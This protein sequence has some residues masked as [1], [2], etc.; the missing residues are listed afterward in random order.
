MKMQAATSVVIS[1]TVNL[2][3]LVWTHR[4]SYQ[5]HIQDASV[6]PGGRSGNLGVVL[7]EFAAGAA[8][9]ASAT[10]TSQ[11]DERLWESIDR[12]M[13]V[14]S[15]LYFIQT[16]TGTQIQENHL[17]RQKQEEIQKVCLGLSS[18]RVDR[19]EEENWSHETTLGNCGH[20]RLPLSTY[21]SWKATSVMRL[22]HVC[23]GGINACCCHTGI[24]SSNVTAH[25]GSDWCA[26]AELNTCSAGKPTLRCIGASDVF[27]CTLWRSAV[28]RREPIEHR[29]PPAEPPLPLNKPGKL[30]KRFGGG[31]NENLHGEAA[32]MNARPTVKSEGVSIIHANEKLLEV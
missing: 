13:Q 19:G 8:S 31:G 9:E 27:V 26:L 15:N 28:Q 6:N 12:Y 23:K 3:A 18:F 22:V 21:S 17:L 29:R 4:L 24:E 5:S 32:E 20:P 14:A 25:T 30:S 10:R 16:C 7:H 11:R 2:T 1:C